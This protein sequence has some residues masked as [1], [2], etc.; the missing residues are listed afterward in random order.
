[1]PEDFW[2][3]VDEALEISKTYRLTEDERKHIGKEEQTSYE[4]NLKSLSEILEEYKTNLEE[5]GFWTEL[6]LDKGGLRFRYNLQGYYGPGGFSSQFHIAGP[7]IVG[8]I[9]PKGDA[10]QSYY[11]N[12]IDQC[13]KIGADYLPNSFRVFVERN[14]KNFLRP[15]NL[16]ITREQYDRIRALYKY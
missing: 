2:S 1:M 15:E 11:P 6:I 3:T 7:L 16:I 14:I 10:I 9:N 12:D 8:E 5:R 4:A 13:E